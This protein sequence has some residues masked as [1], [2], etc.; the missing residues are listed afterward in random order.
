VERLIE[1]H[2][3]VVNNID[4]QP[5]RIGKNC[6]SII[7]LTLSTR[8]VGALAT[9]EID[10][11]RATTSDHEVI[12]FAW[13]PLNDMAVSEEATAAPNW[14]IDGLCADEQAMEEASEYWHVLCEGRP[15]VDAQ[16]AT[17]EE[18]EAEANWIQENLKAVLDR[19]APR[20]SARARSKRWWTEE[21]KQERRVFGRARRA[22]KNSRISFD[23]Y[24]RMRNQYYRHIR[25][26]KRLAWER[27]LEGVFP[28]DEHSELTDDPERCWR[29]LR[30]TKPQV[31]SYTPAIRVSGVDGRPDTTAATAEEK[32]KIF[33]A[34][35]FP[36]QTR[37]GGETA[38]P[39]SVADVS[40]REV[41]EALFAQS[42]KKAPGVDGIGFKALR[43][44][45]Q[46]AEDRVVPLV[47]GCIRMGYHSCTWKIAKGI[48]LRKQGKPTYTAAN[49]YRVISLLSCFGKVVEKVVATWIAVCLIVE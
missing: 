7:D 27:F 1:R 15:P 41:R 28:T 18:L 29:A 25:K 24:C 12:V 21:I 39:D 22:C 19:H 31:P 5:T 14:N 26:A 42:V 36:S 11:D 43:L 32:E 9:W 37:V 2:E 16:T 20:T 23:E 46:W 4:C 38:F 30:Y 3:L 8:N 17:V 13:A 35:A 34:Q 47:Q 45:W 40:A 49:A 48:L 6:R 33:M 10:S 44:L